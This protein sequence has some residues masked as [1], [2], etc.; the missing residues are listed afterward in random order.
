MQI[1]P[2]P[3]LAVIALA[4]VAVAAAGFL[5]LGARD[6]HPLPYTAV[7][8]GAAD[9]QRAFA[10]QG[11]E[12][13]AR[14]RGAWATELGDARDVVEVT[15]FGEPDLVRRAGFRDLAHGRDCTVAGHLALRWRG[16]VRAIV[17]CDLVR[18]DRAWIVRVDRA[19]AALG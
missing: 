16:N 10:A 19:L 8:Y 11:V 17:N 7:R 13:E 15:V 6:A 12:L 9:A 3:L 14:S 4:L 1:A 2:R 5:A 18:D